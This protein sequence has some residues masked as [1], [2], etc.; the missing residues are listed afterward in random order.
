[1]A[2]ISVVPAA[3]YTNDSPYRM[4]ADEML[5]TRKNFIAPSG[6]AL[7]PFRNPVRKYSGIDINSNATN[8]TIR[9]RADASTSI[10]SSDARNAT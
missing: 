3:P 9:S 8:N 5:P 6:A 1:M 4:T 7:S 2:D 10:P